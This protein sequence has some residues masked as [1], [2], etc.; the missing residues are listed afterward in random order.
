MGGITFTGPRNFAITRD[1]YMALV[2]A[3]TMKGD[4]VAIMQGAP[5]PF[6]LRP[7]RYSDGSYFFPG[8]AYVHGAM[9]GEA[10]EMEKM[11][12]ILR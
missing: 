4:V 5:A 2:P 10:M 12:F 6:L 11:L 9:D 1:R 3:G 8:E 7:T